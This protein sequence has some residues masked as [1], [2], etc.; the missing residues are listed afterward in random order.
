VAHREEILSQAMRSFKNVRPECSVSLFSGSSKENDGD[1]VFATVQTL[2]KQEY[3]NGE[4]FKRDAFDYVV[5]DEFHHA[6]AGNYQKIIDYFTPKFLLG[7]N[8]TVKILDSKTR[9][10]A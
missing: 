1:V 9:N 4:L 3:L 6:A 5:I 10:A 2:G 8:A 7:I